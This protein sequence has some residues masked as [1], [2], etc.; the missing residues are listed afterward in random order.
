M[1]RTFTDEPW[2]DYQWFVSNDRRVVRR[3]NRLID[4]ICRNGHDG[5]GKPEPLQHNLSGYWSRRIT[6]EHR[7]VYA[8]DDD[9]V[10]IISCRFHYE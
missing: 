5:I 2:N 6:S 7:L 8:L 10:V 4:D 3:I 9:A 1:K